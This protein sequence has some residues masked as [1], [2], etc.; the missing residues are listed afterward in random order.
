[1]KNLFP[2]RLVQLLF[3]GDLLETITHLDYDKDVIEEHQNKIFTR[4]C[5]FSIEMNIETIKRGDIDKKIKLLKN[6]YLNRQDMT[7]MG[8]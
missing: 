6:A 4:T 7:H 5:D 2:E 1:M 8:N 3:L